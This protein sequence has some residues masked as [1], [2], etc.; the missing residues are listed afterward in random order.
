MYVERGFSNCLLFVKT[1]NF[2]NKQL[3]VHGKVDHNILIMNTEIA[4]NQY[5]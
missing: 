3:I 2:S 1:H 4:C 5:V